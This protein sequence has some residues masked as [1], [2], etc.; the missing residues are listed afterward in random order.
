MK[1]TT[2]ALA[3]CASVAAVIGAMPQRVEAQTMAACPATS[4]MT[5]AAFAADPTYQGSCAGTPTVYGL[6]FYEMGLCQTDPMSSGTFDPTSAGCVPTFQ[7]SGGEYHD[8][9]GATVTLGSDTGTERPA[10]GDYGV[11]YVVFSNVFTL[12]GSYGFAA[13][14]GAAA[15]N[16]V[17]NG[18][19]TSETA[20][21]AD[22]GG[23]P[24]EFTDTLTTFGGGAGG[25]CD[26]DWAE[27]QANGTL[28]AYIATGSI[29]SGLTTDTSCASATTVVGALTL[30]SPITISSSTTG[31]QVDFSVTNNG[32]S[33]MGSVNGGNPG[34]G[35]GPF[36]ATF[37]V[38]E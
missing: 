18:D 38:L 25:G 13:G 14:G 34:F 35:S 28:N 8:I 1:F 21:N 37:T 17:S 24:Q 32:L 4:S 33:V 20:S 5:L 29:S 36:S 11:A 12:K 22:N 9:A 7:S 26:P 23:T 19:P 10:D 15:T 27:P 16:W 31:L 6:T 30:T 3:L 2:K